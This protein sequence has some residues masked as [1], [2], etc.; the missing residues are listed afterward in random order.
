M[1]AEQNASPFLMENDTN[2]P[3]SKAPL[4][5]AISLIAIV[6]IA[7]VVATLVIINSPKNPDLE[8]T[9]NTPDTASFDD[10]FKYIDGSRLKQTEYTFEDINKGFSY[11]SISFTGTK[12]ITIKHVPKQN[13]YNY[14]GDNFSFRVNFDHNGEKIPVLIESTNAKDANKTIETINQDCEN[15][16]NCHSDYLSG[17]KTL[18]ITKSSVWTFYSSTKSG[19]LISYTINPFVSEDIDIRDDS[20]ARNILAKV[21]MTISDDNGSPYI[22]DMATRLRYP[23]GK[24]I[25][26]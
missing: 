6:V 24:Y 8:A 13:P 15:D 1:N 21:A 9:N 3:K 5:I 14:F 10:S 25:K 4:I 2:T 7:T 12:D 17:A 19:Q 22:E 16:E 26:D 18:L 23:N 20:A 11:A